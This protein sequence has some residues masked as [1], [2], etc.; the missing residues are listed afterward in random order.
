M[1]D[2]WGRDTVL[3]RTLSVLLGEVD[4]AAVLSQAL[5]KVIQDLSGETAFH[6]RGHV[7]NKVV[8]IFQPIT[9]FI[10]RKQKRGRTREKVGV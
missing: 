2:R 1:W 3:Y 7:V 6:K 5:L 4:H 10:G 9:D 8:I